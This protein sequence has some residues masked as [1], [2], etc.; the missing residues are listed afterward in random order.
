MFFIFLFARGLQCPPP[1]PPPF[2]VQTQVPKTKAPFKPSTP[3]GPVFPF[4]S[5]KKSPGTKV[6]PPPRFFYPPHRVLRSPPKLGILKLAGETRENI[7]VRLKPW[8]PPPPPP[9]PKN[10]KPP[11]RDKRD[12]PPPGARP[13]TLVFVSFIPAKIVF[14]PP[15]PFC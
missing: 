5:G 15:K 1:P 2:F 6:F 8:G 11:A 13:A 14:D 12:P 7:G 3:T 10:K 4:F 9:P